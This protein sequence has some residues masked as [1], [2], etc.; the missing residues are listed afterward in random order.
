MIPAD[1]FQLAIAR[2]DFVDAFNTADLTVR[3][4]LIELKGKPQQL[5][6]PNIEALLKIPAG[7]QYPKAEK[8]RV[9]KAA[10]EL[11]A[12][13]KTSCDLVHGVMKRV[14]IAQVPHALFQNV[15]E[16][17]PF[18]RQGLLVSA[19]ELAVATRKLKELAMDLGPSESRA[20]SQ[21]PSIP[22]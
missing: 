18:G 10:D 6:G 11:R 3:A 14:V 21:A 13:K 5:L 20:S 2:S 12:L 7:P 1:E 15:Q 9:D 8:A 16:Q 22:S 4:R 19:A 17:P